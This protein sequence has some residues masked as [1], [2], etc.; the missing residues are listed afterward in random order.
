MRI[1]T[2]SVKEYFQTYLSLRRGQTPVITSDSIGNFV[3]DKSIALLEYVVTK[4]KTY[5]FVL[6][7]KEDGETDLRV[8]PISI[9]ADD[10]EKKTS[11][12]RRMMADRNPVFAV[13]SGELYELLVKP[14]EQQLRG[15]L[16]L[17]IIPDGALWDVP[18]QAL[19]SEAERYL[20]EDH[21]LYYAPSLSILNEMTKPNSMKAKRTQPSLI[22]FGNPAVGGETVASLREVKRGES[23][24]PLPEA[25]ME[26]TTLERFFGI[27]Q[28]KVFVGINAT[29][30]RFKALA[31]AYSMV[32]LAT[33]GVLD[34]R[35]PLYSYL[36]LSK[37]NGVA[38]D[39]GLLEAREIMSMNLNADLAVLS[40]CET[41]RG[42]IGAG[43]GVIGMSWAF[44]VAGVRTTIV[45][46]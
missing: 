41:A 19:H 35:N 15:K 45:S 23:F 27:R 1:L 21:A 37:A 29:E 3:Q 32:H 8:Y 7:R 14:A 42:R 39:D 6:T 2:T 10:L 30:N 24:E 43:E 46:Q 33:H 12:F 38:K 34:N 4:D 28:S 44:F 31:P 22:A 26:V 18:F 40:A 25:E 11:K 9:K 16:T 13:A 20:I 17:C 5:L 36:F